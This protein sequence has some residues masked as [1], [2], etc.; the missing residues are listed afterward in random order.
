MFPVASAGR[1]DVAT[2]HIVE[3]DG[4]RRVEC[5]ESIQPPTPRKDK[6][7]LMVSTLFGC[8]VGCRICDAGG[9]YHGKLTAEEIMDQIDFLLKTRYPDLKFPC[10]QLKIQF[11]RM[12]EPALNMAVLD[13]LSMLRGRYEIQGLIPSISTVAPATAH[14]FFEELIHI[15]ST[16]YDNGRFQFQ[17]SLHSTDETIRREIIPVKT[18]D[19][20]RMARYGD[21]FYRA[22]DRK[23]TLNFAVG[24]GIPLEAAVLQH[25][26]D[27]DVF[28]IK[29]T[30]LNPTYRAREYGYTS[31]ISRE[32]HQDVHKFIETIRMKGYDVILSIGEPEENHIGSNCGQY[33]RAHFEQGIKH[34]EAYTYEIVES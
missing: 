20:E 24:Q 31:A 21:R 2:I 19:F 29:I 18:W 28:L 13:V 14:A 9:H 26:F 4:G 11:S 6:W 22:G 15:K 3:Y 8:P 17:F 33:L 34:S 25:Y 1:E 30:P 16:Y 12:G 7:V 32:N 10:R 23:I 5:V 27:P